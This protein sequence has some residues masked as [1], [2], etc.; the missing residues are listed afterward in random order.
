MLVYS[1]MQEQISGTIGS[2]L[3][4]LIRRPVPPLAAAMGSSC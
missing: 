4:V 3:K 2:I 1:W